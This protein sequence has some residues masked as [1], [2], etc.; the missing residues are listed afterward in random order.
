MNKVFLATG[1]GPRATICKGRIVILSGPS[2]SGK[3]TL[4]KKILSSPRLRNLLVRS[5]SVTT[6]PRRPGERSGRD[7]IFMSPEQ[8]ASRRKKGFFLEWKKVFAHYYGTPLAPVKAFLKRGK[9]VLLAI[10]V[11]GARD[12]WRKVPRA[13]KIFVK[14]PT[15]AVLKKRLLQ[16]QTE[17]S[18]DLAVRLRVAK[19]ELKEATHYDYVLINDSLERC[20]RELEEILLAELG[21]APGIKK[22]RG[23]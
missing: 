23:R 8:F 5:V 6:R 16:R 4:Y 1:H 3:T 11:K 13:L 7:Y 22:T 15:F 18:R 10:D 17:N 19:T 9:S 14:T 12:V 20:Y 21:P 2:G